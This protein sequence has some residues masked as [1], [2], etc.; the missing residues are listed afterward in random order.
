M[1]FTA[2]CVPTGMNAGVSTS[3]CAVVITPRRARPSVCVKRN[4]NGGALIDRRIV[5]P[6]WFRPQARHQRDALH[7][8]IDRTHASAHYRKK[9]LTKDRV[10]CL[11]S[12]SSH[13]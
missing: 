7:D 2:P 5:D 3:P 11:T 13:P 8:H 10:L 9:F 4:A 1:P 6:L 12:K